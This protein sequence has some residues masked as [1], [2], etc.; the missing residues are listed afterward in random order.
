[1]S[2]LETVEDIWVLTAEP[3][4]LETGAHY[5]AVSLPW[6]FNRMMY[7]TSSKSQKQRA[8]NVAKGIVGQEILKRELQ[9]I[10]IQAETQRKSHR[11]E[12]LFDLNV[13][14]QGQLTRLDLKTVNYY[15]DYDSYGRRQF[16]TD[17]LLNYAS[18]AGPNWRTFFPMLVPHTQID[19]NKEAYCFAIASS[20]DIR[21][22]IS[23]D[24]NAYALTAF[25]YGTHQAFLSSKKLCSARE[26]QD[27]GFY[28]DLYYN[29]V[30]LFDSS[31]TISIL[32]EWATDFIK[33]DIELKPG[34]TECLGPFSC[35]SSFQIEKKQ[36]DKFNGQIHISVAENEL[37]T[38]ILNSSKRDINIPPSDPLVIGTGDFCNLILPNNYTLYVIGWINKDDFLKACRQYTAWIW[39]KDSVDKYQNQPWSEISEDDIKKLK[40]ADL[41]DAYQSHP[42]RINAGWLKTTGRGTGACC[43]VFPN[44]PRAGGVRETNLYVLPKDLHTMASI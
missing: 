16:T 2:K 10:G 26:S 9:R 4:D 40:K 43:Y 24:R 39:P 31:I 8:L 23:K 30:G 7:N 41:A 28:V 5:A 27:L 32:G 17:H 20:I 14:I 29:D 42:P 6:T 12:D 3:R 25:P 13:D 1:M 15:T 37:N 33:I 19:Q 21:E 44:V 38:S 18:Y 34:V 22:N 11:D 35:I 36:Y